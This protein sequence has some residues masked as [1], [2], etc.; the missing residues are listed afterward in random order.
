MDAVQKEVTDR[1]RREREKERRKRE[2]KRRK[3]TR[4]S[5]RLVARTSVKAGEERRESEQGR[6][7]KEEGERDGEEREYRGSRGGADSCD[8]Q[9]SGRLRE[10]RRPDVPARLAPG[11]CGRIP[12]LRQVL[13]TG[14]ACRARLPATRTRYLHAQ[15]LSFTAGKYKSNET[16]RVCSVAIFFF[17]FFLFS[18]FRNLFAIESILLVY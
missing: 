6:R 2:R 11:G 5:E 7:K 12:I 14:V 1:E 3:E 4:T 10:C 15:T 18:L 16:R 17:F 8:K 13:S 9:S